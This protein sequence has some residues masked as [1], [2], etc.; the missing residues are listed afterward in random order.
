L[1]RPYEEKK[2]SELE[3]FKGYFLS[4]EGY[5]IISEGHGP[6]LLHFSRKNKLVVLKDLGGA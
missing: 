1:F 5:K 4:G 2:N 3:K 6:N